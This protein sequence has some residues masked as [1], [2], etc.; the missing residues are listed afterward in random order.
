MNS[1]PSTV[2]PIGM[3]TIN[4]QLKYTA[5]I[6]YDSL[7]PFCRQTFP[8]EQLSRIIAAP[9]HTSC[10]TGPPGDD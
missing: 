1:Q 6:E 9:V 10:C 7:P 5:Q 2:M 4:A 3:T 8:A